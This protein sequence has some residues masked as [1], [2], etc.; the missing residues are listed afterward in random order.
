MSKRRDDFSETT[1]RRLAERVAYRC[2]SPSCGKQTTGPH[3]NPE[4]SIRIGKAAHIFAAAPGGPRYSS[5]QLSEERCSIQNGIWLC[6]NCADL[7]DKDADAFSVDLLRDWKAN[8]EAAALKELEFSYTTPVPSEVRVRIS[9]LL[10]EAFDLLAGNEGAKRITGIRLSA[11]ELERVRRIIEECSIE[12]PSLEKVKW[13]EACYFMAIGEI[14]KAYDLAATCPDREEP[15]RLL[16]QSH[17]LHRLGR[18]KEAIPLLLQVMGTKDLEATACYNLGLAYD[19]CGEVSEAKAYYDR[20]LVADPAYAYPHSRLA[21]IAY[22]SGDLDSAVR[23]S[24]AACNLEPKDSLLWFRLVLVLLEQ[25]QVNEAISVL[26]AALER[27][28]ADADLNGLKGRA[29]GQIGLL[30]EAESALRYSITLDAR[31][32]TGWYNLGFCLMLKGRFDEGRIAMLRALE[33]GY[34][35]EDLLGQLR[36]ME[37]QYSN[38]DGAGGD[39]PD[40]DA[41]GSPACH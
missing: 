41:F 20:S 24:R 28:P 11:R 21:K 19:D 9:K 36:E 34:P 3:S 6:S 13:L 10:Y 5:V 2:S 40:D 12:A 29:L 16:V 33:Y 15:E 26:E 39:D 17:C 18:A 32:A 31:N 27:F 8:A 30:D 1:K 25:H 7:I 38:H 4:K 37:A 35:D 23:H 22:D 14:G